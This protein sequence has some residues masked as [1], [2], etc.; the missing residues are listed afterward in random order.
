MPRF[1]CH[2]TVRMF[3]K[4]FMEATT[5]RPTVVVDATDEEDASNVAESQLTKQ[6]SHKLTRVNSVSVEL[7]RKI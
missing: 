4:G 7:I 6:Y 2:C 5:A 3:D 1:C